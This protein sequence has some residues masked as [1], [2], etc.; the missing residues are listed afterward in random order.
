[1]EE[2]YDVSIVIPTENRSHLLSDLLA[3]LKTDRDTYTYGNS[4]V[5]VVD[6]SE[7]EEK[8][9]IMQACHDY[10]ATYYPGDISVRKKRNYGIVTAKYPYIL[11][12]DSDVTVNPGLIL[13][14]MKTFRDFSSP[15]LGG[16]LG[17]TEFVGRMTFWWK[18]LSHTSLID[19]FSFARKYPFLSWTIGNNV[20]FRKEVL[21]EIGM[22]EENFPFKL[23]GDDLDMTYRV[24]KAGYLIKSCPKAVTYHSRETWNNVKAIHSRAKRWGTMEY[25]IC[26]RHPE[27]YQSVI[28]R[29]CWIN[30]FVGLLSVIVSFA[31]CK[32]TPVLIGITF[33]LLNIF[34]VYILDMVTEKKAKN[35]FYYLLAKVIHL[36]YGRYRVLNF[37]KHKMFNAPFRGMIFSR[38]QIRYGMD[39]EAKRIWIVLLCFVCSVLLTRFL[40]LPVLGG[41]FA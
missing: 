22:F 39:Y 41:V 30:S 26:K 20:S 31:V 32:Y 6:S 23:G 36:H 11:F 21:L 4:E 17:Y 2:R 28:P 16:V 33:V 8:K 38:Y 18:L 40:F 24:T 15:K 3:S 25:H 10:D 27:V 5:I 37:F 9:R 19:S 7:G 1:M 13:S 14:H 29:S 12:I 34:G 35:P